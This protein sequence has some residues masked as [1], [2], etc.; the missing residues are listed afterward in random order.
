MNE[1]PVEFAWH[2]FGEGPHCKIQNPGGRS[3]IQ[4]SIYLILPICKMKNDTKHH[5]STI[6]LINKTIV[7]FFSKA[8]VE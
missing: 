1:L 7:I 3:W 8:A 4:I 2:L 6:H 5:E